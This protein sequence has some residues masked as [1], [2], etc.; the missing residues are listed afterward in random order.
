AAADIAVGVPEAKIGFTEVKLG[1]VPAVISPFVLR[2]IGRTHAARYF[3]TGEIFD[4]L[5]AERIGLLQR[6]VPASELETEVEGLVASILAA[7]PLAVRESKRLID[8]VENVP[9]RDC[10]QVTV[11]LIARLRVSDEGQEG[12]SAFLD[13]RRP[14]WFAEERTTDD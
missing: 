9:V 8:L 14:A 12:M 5:E 10:D 6:C 2:K 13:K 3:A 1:I 11:P 7:G 4:G